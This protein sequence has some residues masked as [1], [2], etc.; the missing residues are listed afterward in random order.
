MPKR[1]LLAAVAAGLAAAA[2][3]ATVYLLVRM[4]IRGAFEIRPFFPTYDVEVVEAGDGWITLR[5]GGRGRPSNW[6]ADVIVGLE[7]E[8]GYGRLGPVLLKHGRSVVREYTPVVGEAAAGL[9]ARFDTF[10][11]PLDPATAHGIHFDELEVPGE[12]SALPA[13]HIPAN[14]DTWLIFVHGKG[15]WRGEALRL[16]PLARDLEMPALSIAYRGDDGVLADPTRR[17]AYGLHEWRDLEAAVRFA[18]DH[19]A[20]MV[21]PVGFS[22]GGGIVVNFLLR[23]ALRSSASGAILDSPML[24]LRATVEHQAALRGHPRAATAIVA[25][26]ARLGRVR[27]RDF[28][29]LQHAGELATPILLLH[30]DAD[31]DVPVATS[32]RLATARPDIVEY[33]RTPGVGHVLSWNAH[34]AAY[35]QRVRA[36]LQRIR[37]QASRAYDDTT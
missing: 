34:P 1:V 25:R 31:P 26:A 17:Y 27:W 16:L 18:L 28:D 37:R 35:E 19:G 14:G 7:W 21:V 9:R 22:M 24:D 2:F 20:R 33:V 6:D 29:Y 3:V 13:W 15:A 30:G 32:D 12:L 10:A 5:P 36:F 4:L 23:S 11:F 8:G